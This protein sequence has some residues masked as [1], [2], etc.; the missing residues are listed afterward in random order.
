VL[1]MHTKTTAA[2]VELVSCNSK[3]HYT[4]QKNPIKN[5]Q[6]SGVF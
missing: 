4:S 3:T 1:M 5:A 6:L 2:P